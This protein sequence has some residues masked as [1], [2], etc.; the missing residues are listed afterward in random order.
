LLSRSP[1]T[2]FPSKQPPPRRLQQAPVVAATIALVSHQEATTLY[3]HPMIEHLTALINSIPEENAQ[4]HDY[5]TNELDE[6][7]FSK[8]SSLLMCAYPKFLNGKGIAH[9]VSLLSSIT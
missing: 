4:R 8:D 2:Q 7:L 6:A 1:L 9:K 3:K 5:Q